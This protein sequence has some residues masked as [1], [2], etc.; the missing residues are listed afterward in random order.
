MSRFKAAGIHLL[1]SVF[2][3]ALI[4]AFYLTQWYPPELLEMSR[5]VQLLGILALVDVVIGPLLTLI[6]FNP[7]KKSLKFDLSV[8][9]M[10]QI[11]A[12]AFGLYTMW[13]TRPVFLVAVKDR[14]ELVFANEIDPA[15]LA[16]AK[17]EYRSLSWGKP[18]LVSAPP[19]TDSKQREELMFSGLAG[20]DIQHTPK[21][22]QPYNA[23]TPFLSAEVEPVSALIAARPQIKDKVE[24]V[25]KKRGLDINGIG[26]VPLNSS[27]DAAAM[28]VERE[29]TTIIGPLAADPWI[30][31][32]K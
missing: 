4:A 13:T 23:I 25:A 14:F 5:G 32:A 8:I 12:M 30:P 7:A 16:K 17:P 11:G 27:R 10:L 3:V 15:D 18:T 1:I 9:A 22:Y 19:P 6:V 21:L 24:S 20:K 26:F 2:V 29:T 31:K 28:L